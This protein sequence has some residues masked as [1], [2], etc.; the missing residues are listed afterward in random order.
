MIDFAF[1]P[2]RSR[3]CCRSTSAP[4]SSC[5]LEPTDDLLN[6]TWQSPPSPTCTCSGD[7]SLLSREG[8]G[9][10]SELNTNGAWREMSTFVHYKFGREIMCGSDAHSIAFLRLSSATC[11]RAESR[12]DL[13]FSSSICKRSSASLED[14]VPVS[15]AVVVE[16]GPFCC[17][18][19]CCCCCFCCSP[20]LSRKVCISRSSFSFEVTS[21]D[22]H[23][24]R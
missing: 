14:D 10:S 18:C 11:S 5:I 20:P 24:G 1:L 7:G 23:I 17:C 9:R 19:C 3:I 22:L 21:W 13:A 2:W 6:D 4:S 16:D 15:A 12:S 8:G